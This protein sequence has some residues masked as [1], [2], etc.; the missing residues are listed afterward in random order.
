MRLF[1]LLV[2]FVL[3]LGQSSAQGTSQERDLIN[4]YTEEANRLI[5]HINLNVKQLALYQEAINAWYSSKA[6]KVINAPSYAFSAYSGLN[7]SQEILA[8]SKVLPSNPAFNYKNTLESL[9]KQLILFDSFCQQLAKLKK[10][11]S[12]DDFYN[13]TMTILYQMDK[14]APEMVNLCYEFSL[15]CAINFGK[16]KLPVELDRLKNTVGQAKNVIMAIRENDPIQVK[17]YLNQLD[18]AISSGMANQ[19]FNDLKRVGRFYADEAELKAIYNQVLDAANQIAFWAEQYLQSNFSAQ[20]VAPILKSSI[21]AFNVYEG[22]AGSSGAYNELVAQSKNQYLFFTEEP[23]FFHVEET[24]K[25][26]ELLV[27][28]E[29]KQDTILVSNPVNKEIAKVEPPVQVEPPKV[30]DANDISTLDGSL[31]NNIIIMMDV[32]AS[33]KLTGKL[34]LLKS[35]ILHLVDIMRPEDRLSLIAY[36][37]KAEVLIANAGVMDKQAIRT[38]LDTLHSSGGTDVKKGL[39]LGYETALGSF[40]E[41]GNNRIIIATD[42]EFGVRKDL[43]ELVEN[44]Q[45]NQVFLSIFQFNGSKNNEL[46]EALVNLAHLG[47]GSY[48]TITNSNEALSILMQEVKKK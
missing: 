15:S 27:K 43:L 42:G 8:S 31:P 6:S 21:L 12:K 41:D 14:I 34:P 20:E 13:R 16:E 29:V 25:E 3:N 32:S 1:V 36:S 23:I 18:L 37:G 19:H 11:G 45:S 47:K 46:N 26:K 22:K 7:E 17:S 24:E 48:K 35:S 33:M 44:N 28:V 2:F 9:N 38:V 5:G 40:M 4:S 39:S 10:I 30:F